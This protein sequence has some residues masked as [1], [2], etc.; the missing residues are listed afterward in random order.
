M[1]EEVTKYHRGH[2]PKSLNAIKRGG[3][4]PG[5]SGN[6]KGRP[7]GIHYVSEALR[8][9]L[10]DPEVAKDLA[11]ELMKRAKKRDSAMD[12]LLDRTEGKV[13]QPIGIDPTMPVVIDRIV[14]HIA[15][16]KQNGNSSG[17]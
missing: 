4:K 1:S 11:Q 16:D 13:T 3:F 5:Q 14:A 17:T 9:L 15:E 7:K 8:E 6:P 10:K 2:H 12:I